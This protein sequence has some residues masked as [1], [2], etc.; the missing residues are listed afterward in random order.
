MYIHFI[1][2][3]ISGNGKHNLTA[4]HFRNFFPADYRIEV[5]YTKHKSHATTLTE[6]AILAKPDCIVACGGDGTINEVASCLVN[7]NIKL[8]IIPVGSGNGLASHLAIPKSIDR[9]L[10]VIK[11]GNVSFIDVGK[12]NEKYFFSN[13]GIGIDAMIIKQ[14]ERSGKRTLSAYVRAALASSF[15][16]K[17]RRTILADGKKIWNSDPLMLFVSNS[18]EMGYNR[19]LTP[20]AS[21][22]DGQ[23]DLFMVPELSFFEKLQLGYCVL[24]NHV[25][26]FKK[27]THMLVQNLHLEQPETIFMDIQIDGEFH[28]FKTNILHISI[29]H[30]GLRV[31]TK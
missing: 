10:E 15:K 27:G 14:Y 31:V 22:N 2:N 16:F 30:K 11:K 19:S 7:S 1:V 5:G 26:R 23:L 28:N 17:P 3:P 25:E 29:L 21:L 13:M 18:N 12:V 20:K 6:E 4:H 9:A 24:A 8:G